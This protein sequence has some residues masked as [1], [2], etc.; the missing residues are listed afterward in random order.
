MLKSKCIA[1]FMSVSALSLS[2]RAETYP[3]RPITL[4]VPFA[5]G[6]TVN[7]MGRLVAEHMGEKLGQ[8]VVVD[9]KA[10]AGG[11][12]G[13]GFVAKAAPD[14]YTLLLGSMGQAV[15]S[16]LTR[17]LPYDPKK[18]VPVALFS[19]VS[20]VLAVSAT[21]PAKSVTDLIGYS[22]ANPGKLNMASAG[23]GSIN[24]L[25]GE[26]FMSRTGASFVHVPYKGAGPAGVDLL[27]G[28]VQLIFAN[29]P[30]VLP[31]AKAGK[32]RLLAVASE[33]RDPAIPDVPTF[34]E[35]GVKDAVVESW[36]GLMA[37]AG[38]K[39]EVVKQLQDTLLT[40]TRDKR[41]ISQLAEQGAR[42]YPGSGADMAQL[43]EKEGTRW[44]EVID[45][46]R[47]SLD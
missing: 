22:K 27:S 39:P 41:F 31:Y 40:V 15:Q 29:L 45:Q 10:G 46:A 34:A 1:L 9:N 2:V 7:M 12:I 13:A 14:G 37:P 11:A 16:L 8:P 18:L 44:R 47:I 6:G 28:Q 35:A 42:P 26:L 25:I 38:T 23:V 20:N 36:Y 17:R 21:A 3:S 4:V 43:M 19:T 5:A 24:H 32:V 33:R 30:N